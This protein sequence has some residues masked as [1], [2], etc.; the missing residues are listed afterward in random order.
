MLPGFKQHFYDKNWAHWIIEGF[1][2]R[3]K[4]GLSVQY[5]NYIIRTGWH[6]G[7]ENTVSRGWCWC[8]GR[9]WWKGA[10]TWTTQCNPW[11]APGD[12]IMFNMLSNYIIV[13]TLQDTSYKNYQDYHGNL[14]S[15]S[16][17]KGCVHLHRILGGNLNIRTT[18][19]LELNQCHHFLL[20]SFESSPSPFSFYHLFV[21]WKS[22]FSSNCLRAK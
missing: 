11:R 20:N 16:E 18:T 4:G 3:E 7:R 22:P 21:T 17:V 1:T 12:Q 13:S 8:C 14:F 9:C 5:W 15:K 19:T 2:Y 6:L 10:I